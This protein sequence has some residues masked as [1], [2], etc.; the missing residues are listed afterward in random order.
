[1][2]GDG[3]DGVRIVGAVDDRALADFGRDDIGNAERFIAREGENVRETQ[4][5][6][7]MVYEGPRWV[8][9]DGGVRIACAAQDVARAILTREL[10]ALRADLAAN[11]ENDFLKAAVSAH[12]AW[13]RQSGSAPRLNAMISQALPRLQMPFESWNARSDLFNL[14]GGTLDLSSL[15]PRLRSHRREDYIT[16]LGACDFVPDAPAPRFR[17]FIEHML[18]DPDIRGFVQRAC[19]SCLV[20]SASDQVMIVFHGGGANGKSTFLDVICD[21]LGDY[22]MSVSVNSFLANDRASGSAP[23]P[24]LVRFAHRPRLVRTSEPQPGARLNESVIKEVTGGEP[25][26]VRDLHEKPIEIRINFKI[27]FSCNNRPSIRG[28]DDGIWRR[29]RL[30]PW[31]V[32]IPEG[33]RDPHLKEK[34][35]EERDGIFAW[36]LEGWA[37]WRERGGLDAPAAVL[38]A[39]AEYRAESDAVGR[40]LS[41]SCERGEGRE[42]AYSLLYDSY[43][44]WA[45]ADGADPVSKALL[46]RRLSDRGFGRKDS[47]GITYRTGLDLTP[48]ARE[49]GYAREADRAARGKKGGA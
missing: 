42:V 22:A 31:A 13:G 44:E 29:I 16:R 21:V 43:C 9:D 4:R 12:A 17:A 37:D 8:N 30:V 24:D 48:A 2:S 26:V 49:A 33:D 5:Y 19:G 1:M 15:E 10:P 18:P 36:L 47:N 40:F 38:E 39:G 20:D 11:P 14:P 34:L 7:R 45:T 28:G 25:M 32:Q 3:G 23:Q 6:A 27:F 46:S 35:L 41:D